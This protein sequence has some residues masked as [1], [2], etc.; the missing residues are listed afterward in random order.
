LE[1]GRLEISITPPG[2]AVPDAT[3]VDAYAAAGVDRLILRPRPEVDA[4]GLERFAP[5]T[6]RALR[7]NG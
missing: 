6:G 2:F 7:L 1:L 3:T 4:A 5:D